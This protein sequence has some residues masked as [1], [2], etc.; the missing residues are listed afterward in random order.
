MGT[1]STLLDAVNG[2]AT[3]QRAAIDGLVVT[4]ANLLQQAGQQFGE[5]IEAETARMTEAAAQ[6][7][8]GAVEVASLGEAFG[9][10][11]QMFSDSSAALTQ[12]LQRIE[13]ALNKST[14]RSDEQ[15][16]Y[17]VAQAR[18]LI[19][20]SISSQQQIVQDLQQLAVRRAP[21]AGEVA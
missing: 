6:V 20:L 4:S 11:V 8:G 21:L 15:L 19:D 13:A 17:Y 7:A 1:L 5:R 2:A 3:E 9:A 18:E 12:H 16:A 14:T 10:A